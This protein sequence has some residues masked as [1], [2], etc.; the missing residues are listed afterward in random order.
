MFVQGGTEKKKAYIHPDLICH[1]FGGK[2]HYFSG[3]T[4]TTTA[5]KAAIKAAKQASWPAKKGGVA[6]NVESGITEKK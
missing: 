3:C 6:T 5:A 4:S 1:S 2:G